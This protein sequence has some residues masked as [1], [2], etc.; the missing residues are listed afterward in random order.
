ML[1]KR[2][3][4][5]LSILF[6]AAAIL[7]SPMDLAALDE[8]IERCRRDDVLPVFAG[9]VQRRSAFVTAAY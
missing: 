9:E 3:A 5:L 2:L 1:E 4:M 6:T 8:A 7:A